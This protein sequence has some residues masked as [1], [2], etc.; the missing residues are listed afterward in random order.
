MV[1]KVFEYGEVLPVTSFFNLVLAWTTVEKSIETVTL[2]SAVEAHAEPE[3]GGTR[4]NGRRA[5]R[6]RRPAAGGRYRAAPSPHLV[7]ESP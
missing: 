6:P 1:E 5:P 3:R 4:E 7:R 2:Q